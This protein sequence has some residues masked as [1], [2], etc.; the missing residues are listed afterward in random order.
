MFLYSILSNIDEVLL[1]NP[2]ANLFVFVDFNIHH[3]DWLTYS[4][5]PDRVGES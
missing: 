4:G 2:Y 1:I 3:K 5:G